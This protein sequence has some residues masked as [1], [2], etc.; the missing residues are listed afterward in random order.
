LRMLFV[1]M[2]NA[3]TAAMLIMPFSICE[4]LAVLCT[5]HTSDPACLLQ[6]KLIFL[7][8][9]FY[10]VTLCVRVKIQ[11]LPQKSTSQWQYE[12]HPMLFTASISESCQ[13]RWRDN[14]EF[15]FIGVCKYVGC[16]ESKERLRIQ[17]AQLLHCTRSVVWCVQ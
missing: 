8:N 5:L 6:G 1:Y 3:F 16:S 11:K 7:S 9:P 2:A 12:V 17:P 10:T 4:L 15:F 13:W 14:Y